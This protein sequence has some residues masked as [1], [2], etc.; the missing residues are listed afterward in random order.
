MHDKPQTSMGRVPIV[1]HYP[2]LDHSIK[3]GDD[4]NAEK[5]QM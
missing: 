1:S 2:A 4:K 5:Q 3:D